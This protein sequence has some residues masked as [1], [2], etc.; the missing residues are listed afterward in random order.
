[1]SDTAVRSKLTQEEINNV[2]W[3]ACDTFRGKTDSSVYKDYILVMLFVKYLSDTYK[4]HYE[5]YSHKYKWR[6]GQNRTRLAARPVQP[7]RSL[8]FD[9]LYKHR[10]ATDI[11][12][13]IDKA[14]EHIEE[15]KK[16]SCAAYS[17]ISASTRKSI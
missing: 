10:N 15:S 2:L 6:R 11:G 14:L 12:E 5:E 13:K 1:M 16:P 4:E 3:R 9:Y 7:P 17:A 8:N